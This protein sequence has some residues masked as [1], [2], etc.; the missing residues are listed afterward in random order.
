MRVGGG[1]C[2]MVGSGVLDVGRGNAMDGD[3]LLCKLRLAL[4][5][6]IW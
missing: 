2:K 3:D 5:G 6:K 4:E 1:G